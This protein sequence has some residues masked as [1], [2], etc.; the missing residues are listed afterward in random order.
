MQLGP[1]TDRAAF[2]AEL[3]AVIDSMMKVRPS[4]KGDELEAAVREVCARHGV[5]A[6]TTLDT[7]Q[8]SEPLRSI[9]LH[10][11]AAARVHVGQDDRGRRFVT[12]HRWKV[13]ID[14]AQVDELRA[15]GAEF[16]EKTIPAFEP[17]IGTALPFEASP[18]P[19]AM[20]QHFGIGG[21]GIE[22][23]KD[24]FTNPVTFDIDGV[25][26]AVD[27]LAVLA[28]AGATSIVVDQ[29]TRMVE[30]RRATGQVAG[31]AQGLQPLLN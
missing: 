4:P 9:I 1:D 6:G 22:D 31:Y 28:V 27:A 15:A 14:D 16:R 24:G 30:G 17:I 12:D 18:S 25:L 21:T 2:Q 11:A 5:T 8:L 19:L 29:T 20:L 26:F 13:F 10:G 23:T 7:S 3:K